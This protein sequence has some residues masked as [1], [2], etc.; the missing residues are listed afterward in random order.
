MLIHEMTRQECLDTLARSGLGRLACARDNQPYVVPF[1]FAFD[2][3]RLYAFSTL[4]QKIEWM[5]ANPRV[6]VETDERTTHNQW[7]SIVVV[8]HYEELPDTPEYAQERKRAHWLLQQRAMWWEPAY[9]ASAHHG[10]A[11]SLTPIFFCLHVDRVTGQR[12]TPNSFSVESPR[13]C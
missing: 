2:T 9:V 13:V 12:A 7:V 1:Y 4:G 11:D 6:C 3:E 10:A 5:R 8:G